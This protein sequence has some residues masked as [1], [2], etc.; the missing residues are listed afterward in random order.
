LNACLANYPPSAIAPP[1]RPPDQHGLYL[2]AE[3]PKLGIS[4]WLK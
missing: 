2:T 1:V 4:R 3:I